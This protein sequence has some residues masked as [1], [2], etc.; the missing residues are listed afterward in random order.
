[1]DERGPSAFDG[2]SLAEREAVGEYGEKLGTATGVAGSVV[3]D[4]GTRRPLADA[5]PAVPE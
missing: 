2:D 5:R 4:D 1:M 3:R